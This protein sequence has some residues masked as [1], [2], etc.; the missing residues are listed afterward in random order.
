MLEE[1]S[2]RQI[3]F[4]ILFASY[5]QELERLRLFAR[6]VVNT[7]SHLPNH[8]ACYNQTWQCLNDQET[9]WRPGEKTRL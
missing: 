3:L 9:I 6:R 1:R 5:Y 2:L 4:M 8:M 7:Y